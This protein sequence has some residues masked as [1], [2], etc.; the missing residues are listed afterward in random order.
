MASQHRQVT[1]PPSRPIGPEAFQQA[2]ETALWW[3]SGAGFLLNSHG[4]LLMIDPV[5][6]HD[7]A[8]PTHSEIG[9]P[10]L[11]APPHT[12]ADVPRLDAVLYTHSDDDHIGSQTPAALLHTGARFVGPPPVVE[13]LRGL[14]VP[15]DRMR[16]ATSGLAHLHAAVALWPPGPMVA[17]NRRSAHGSTARA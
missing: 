5:I 3:L 15:E 14:G 12:G 17:T 7:P 13:K 16:V 4:T 10:L 6:A 8:S 9:L 1:V 11:V 2:D